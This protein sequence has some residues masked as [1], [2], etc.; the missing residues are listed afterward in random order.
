MTLY[1]KDNSYPAP[2]P[3]RIRLPDRST[4]TDPA[5]FTSE[6]IAL[7]GYVVAPDKPTYNPA[8]EHAPQ[9]QNGQW[10]VTPLT[11]EEIAAAARKVWPTVAE[12]WG[13]FSDADKLA[14]LASDIGG[15]IL[16]REEL[17]MW[18]GEVWSDDERVQQ[19]LGGLV[20]VGIL[21]TERREEIL[22]P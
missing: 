2:L 19:G 18:R 17:R 11:P 3:Q 5:T 13:E 10:I 9:W 16:L 15:I 6:E 21:T 4:R 22:Q 12:F 14:I 20:A 8:T 7:S 1:S